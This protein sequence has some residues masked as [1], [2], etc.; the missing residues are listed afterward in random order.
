MNDGMSP[1]RVGL[2]TCPND[3]FMFDALVH[4]RVEWGGPAL[5]T[6][7]EDVE[8]LNRRAM[9]TLR[10]GQESG[11]EF[12][13]LSVPAFASTSEKYGM[14]RS[15]AAL[16][17]GCGPLVVI[18]ADHQAARYVGDPER[19]MAELVGERVAIPGLHTT[20]NLLFSS[21]CPVDAQVQ[22]LRFDEIEGAVERGIVDAGVIIHESR[23]TYQDRG[24]VAIADLGSLWERTYSLPLPLGV[25]A[26]LRTLP[27]T[28]GSAFEAALSRS[29]EFAFAH[30]AASAGYVKEHAQAMSDHVC[31]AHIDLYV[32]SES[33]KISPVGEEAVRKMLELGSAKKMWALPNRLFLS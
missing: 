17:R 7:M 16:G 5:Q 9:E 33:Q 3:T 30:P 13:K 31:R 26:G 1:I 20:A 32:T 15:G 22:E 6:V 24:L 19:A 11:L 2:S 4:G 25:I 27:M 10:G 23:F 18:R 12:T 14:L 29:V 21:F 28:L 8:S